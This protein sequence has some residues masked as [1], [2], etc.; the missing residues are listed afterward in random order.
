MPVVFT[1][2]PNVATADLYT[3]DNYNTFIAANF[4]AGVPDIFTAAGDLAYA[5][6]AD[7]AARLAIG[8]Q[9]T[10]LESTGSAPSWSVSGMARFAD[11]E[12]SI[13][14]ASFDFTSI[15]QTH[16]HLLLV[17]NLRG[18]TAANTVAPN[19]RFNNDSTANYHSNVM[20]ANGAGTAVGQT[21]AGTSASLGSVNA[22]TAPASTAAKFFVFIPD[23]IDV[24]FR[25]GGVVLSD[26]QVALSANNVYVLI[27]AFTLNIAGAVSRITL[28]PAAGNWDIGSR[29]TLYG[30]G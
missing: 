5:T 20:Q 24:T 14:T 10:H 18:D 8:A 25:P 22:G 4:A 12:L 1:P 23:Y 29:A 11:T 27:G 2:V 17:T 19:L 28:L 6:A 7:V 21:I 9:Y 26:F 16:K 13:A 30:I 3:A 15:P